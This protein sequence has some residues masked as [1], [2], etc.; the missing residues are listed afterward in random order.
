[1]RANTDQ[2]HWGTL[3][4]SE[5]HSSLLSSAQP[6]LLSR[7]M[8]SPINLPLAKNCCWMHLLPSIFSL[9]RAWTDRM[10]LAELQVLPAERMLPKWWLPRTY[11][12]VQTQDYFS[13][14]DTVS[15]ILLLLCLNS[16]LCRGCLFGCCY[17]WNSAQP[18]VPRSAVT[19]S[20]SIPK[21]ELMISSSVHPSYIPR[22]QNV[23]L[24]SLSPSTSPCSAIISILQMKKQTGLPKNIWLLKVGAQTPT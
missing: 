7:G 13:G 17:Q 14:H 21:E 11:G 19:Y 1:M 18:L 8:Y 5:E 3:G 20:N 12:W 15:L 10:S 22:D 6:Q 2:S 9:P 23:N 24:Y 4:Y 16:Y